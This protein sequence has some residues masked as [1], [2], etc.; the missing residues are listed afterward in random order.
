VV[1]NEVV[2]E[3]EPAAATVDEPSSFPEVRVSDRCGVGSGAGQR[4]QGHSAVVDL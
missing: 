4:A 2:V 1:D 3:F